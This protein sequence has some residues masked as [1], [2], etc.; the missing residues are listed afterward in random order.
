MMIVF[1]PGPIGLTERGFQ[2]VR[3]ARKRYESMFLQLLRTK[4]TESM[5][6]V[7]MTTL[8]TVHR[9]LEVQANRGARYGI[10]AIVHGGGEI[11]IRGSFVADVSLA[12]L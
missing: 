10:E 4:D 8:S 11:G 1:S 7:K 3:D 9:W 2:I 12:R 5:A 6:I